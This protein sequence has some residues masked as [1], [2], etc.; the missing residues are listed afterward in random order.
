MPDIRDSRM[1]DSFRET[2]DRFWTMGWTF[3]APN[4]LPIEELGLQ[5][6]LQHTTHELFSSGAAASMCFTDTQSV[7]STEDSR[8]GSLTRSALLSAQSSSG[9]SANKQKTANNNNRKAALC[10]LGAWCAATARAM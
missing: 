4:A 9:G 5:N 6:H 1:V 2:R 3:G 7:K 10:I 8:G